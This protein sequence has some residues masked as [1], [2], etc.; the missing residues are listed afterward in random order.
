NILDQVAFQALNGF[1]TLSNILSLDLDVPT[2]VPSYI[3]PKC[4]LTACTTYSYACRKNTFNSKFAVLSNKLS[5]VLDL[6]LHR[7][8]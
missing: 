3:P 4:F 7:L 2:N 5:I 1:T 8:K 6:L